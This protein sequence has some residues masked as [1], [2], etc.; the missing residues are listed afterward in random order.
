MDIATKVARTRFY[1]GKGE[2]N[3]TKYKGAP[4]VDVIAKDIDEQENLHKHLKHIGDTPMVPVYLA[5]KGRLRKVHLKLEG[6]NPA[7]SVKVR[8]ASALVRDLEERGQLRED[9]IILESTSGNL[10]VAI[11]MIARARGY[12]FLAIVDP[13]T[14][15]E[16]RARMQA[17]GAKIETMRRAD[18]TGGYLLARLERVRQLLEQSPRYVWTNQYGNQANPLIHYTW[19][20]PEIYQQMHMRIDAIF[21]AVSTGGTLAGIGRYLR[22]VSPRTRVIGVDVYGSVI[23]GTPPG[24]RKLTGIGASRPSSF[25]TPDLYDRHML[26]HDEEAFA[27]CR[28]LYEATTIKVGGSSGA[29]LAACA[30]Y[31]AEHPEILEVV[32]ICPDTGENYATT[33]YDDGWLQQADV[34]LDGALGEVERIVREPY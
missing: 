4:I 34:S 17:F 8:T 13:K 18:E 25:L 3:K 2:W 9:A 26:V 27:F 1:C 6:A 15:E 16:N 30:H 28:E 29:A 33:I 31:L 19:T 10:G 22:E 21:I 5:I 20:G 32:C 7:G 12:R 24:P 14:T 23:F 11:S